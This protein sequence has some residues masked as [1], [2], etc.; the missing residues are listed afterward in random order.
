MSKVIGLVTR[1]EKTKEAYKK[2]LLEILDG[3]KK[4]V[5]DGEVVEFILSGM[6]TD[7]E[8]IMAA[9]C[10]DMVGGVG[11]LEIAKQSLIQQ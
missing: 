11:M 9:C 5:E 3:F 7:G 1:P 2:D 10:K 6:D 8:V 4:M